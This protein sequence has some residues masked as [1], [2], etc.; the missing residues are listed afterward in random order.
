VSL[1]DSGLFNSESLAV[2]A[3]SNILGISDISMK[4]T[5]EAAVGRKK[6]N[7]GKNFSGEV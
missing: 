2:A 3:F 5:K 6:L 7:T 4:M 1:G